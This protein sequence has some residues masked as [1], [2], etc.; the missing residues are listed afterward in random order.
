MEHEENVTST[1]TEGENRL[2]EML[3][4]SGMVPEARHAALMATMAKKQ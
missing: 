1:K 2:D 4:I 3:T